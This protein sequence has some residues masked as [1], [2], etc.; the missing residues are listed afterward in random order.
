MN[1]PWINPLI[2]GNM[3]GSGIIIMEQNSLQLRNPGAPPLFD[4][5]DLA[6]I[7]PEVEWFAN[8]DNAHPKKT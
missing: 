7:P 1:E 6:D 5:S 3:S 8:L 4:F 2:Q